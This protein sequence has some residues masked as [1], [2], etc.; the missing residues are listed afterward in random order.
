MP[1]EDVGFELL[2]QRLDRQILH[3]ARLA[4]GA[5]VEE[6][7]DAAAGSGRHRF[8]KR[9]DGFRFGVVHDQGFDAL[10]FQS[11]HVGDTPHGGKDP[12][13]VAV[14]RAGAM[15]ADARGAACDDDDGFFRHLCRS[16]KPNVALAR[17]SGP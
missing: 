6:R 13:A 10:I 3:R 8:H 2:A 17:W 14:E 4:I 9:G 16:G 5:V 1:A 11:C 15:G 12:P 7:V